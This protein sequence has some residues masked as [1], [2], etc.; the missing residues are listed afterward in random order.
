[1]GIGK[2]MDM[3]VGIGIAKGLDKCV[4]KVIGVGRYRYKYRYYGIGI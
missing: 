3:G 2:V 1:M 4:G